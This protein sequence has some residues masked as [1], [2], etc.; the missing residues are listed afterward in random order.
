M[1]CVM[2]RV[3][4]LWAQI[5]IGLFGVSQTSAE[6]L[7]SSELTCSQPL[8][9]TTREI[10][11]WQLA[12]SSVR[13]WSE[14]PNCAVKYARL[15]QQGSK[16]WCAGKK[17]RT[18]W[19]LVDLGVASDL[20]GV[21]TQGRSEVDEWVTKFMISYSLDAQKWEHARDIYGNKKEFK[22]NGNAHSLR[23][24]YL[25]HPVKARF[26]R[27]H[28]LSWHGHP[29]MRLEIVGCQECNHI[30]SVT[31]FTEISASSHKKWRKRNKSCMPD[32]GDINSMK[33]WC[34]RRQNED[35]WLQF[36]LGPPTS[37]TGLVTRGQGDK[38]RFVTSYTMSYSNDSSLW[39]FYKDA[40]HLEAKIFGGNMDMVTERRHYLN[41]PVT[42]RYIRIHPLTWHK[43]IG[44]RAAVIGCP[45]KGKCGPGFMQVN[46]GSACVPNKAFLKDTWVNDKRHGRQQWRYGHSSLA[47]DGNLDTNL[48]N[49]A[50]LDNYYTDNPVWM[51]DL[52]RDTDINGVVILTWQGAGQDKI[53]SYTDYVFNLEKLTVYASRK[54]FDNVNDLTFHSK[55]ESVTRMNNALYNPRLHFECPEQK[56][57]RYLYVKATGSPNRWRKLFTVVLCEV[58][59]Y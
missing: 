4:L 23:H 5:L 34:P 11:D 53:T 37:I 58:M 28:V 24:S 47:V 16:A 30:I 54:K 39:F 29:S 56:K 6:D 13:H 20:S 22:G 35:Q 2:D 8:G 18:E 12:A 33:G 1:R 21:V 43:R 48:A 38:K 31:P 41:L 55:C 3:V 51:V 15:H 44:M 57:G 7:S 25:E 26:V 49:C 40:N 27:I 46:T 17:T 32:M 9:M 59:V 10:Q 45:H 19:I 50:N 42:A 14:D 36:D 52:G